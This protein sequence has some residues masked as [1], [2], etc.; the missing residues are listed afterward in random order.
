V[1]LLQAG[2]VIALPDDA[3]PPVPVSL[4]VPADTTAAVSPDDTP[5][6]PFDAQQKVA[7]SRLAGVGAILG[8]GLLQ[9]E[10][11]E[12]P[13][14]ANA[15]G[16]FQRD[17]PEGGADKLGHLYTGYVLGRAFG[18]LYRDWGIAP[19]RAATQAAVTS[20]LITGTMELGDGF[21]PYGI[22]WEDMVMNTAGAWA[23]Q[24]LLRNETW[25]ERLDLRVEYRFNADT[26]DPST[27]YEHSRY[28]VALK[29]AGFAPLRDTPLQ[30]LELHGGYYVR[31]YDD[32]LAPDERT[33]YVGLGVNFSRLLRQG[34]FDRTAT[35]LQFYQP[36][37]TTWRLEDEL[38]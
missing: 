36:P 13:L 33:T 17:T 26:S 4:S 35:V 22:S 25:R 11:G 21:S 1:L 3:V 18:S 29:L 16:W 23:G 38:R 12:Q 2:A 37:E 27:D 31:G 19:D 30:W 34:G 14:N 15:E 10:Y 5:A 28:L 24:A 32:P 9:W 7:L 8:W 6:E 20:L